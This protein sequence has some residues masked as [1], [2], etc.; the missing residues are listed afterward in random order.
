MSSRSVLALRCV[1]FACA[2]WLS[3]VLVPLPANA[4][5]RSNDRKSKPQ[6]SSHIARP[7]S[8]ESTVISPLPVSSYL[9]N[10]KDKAATIAV[11]AANPNLDAVNRFA[12]FLRATAVVLV[13]IAAGL[14]F[15]KKTGLITA[16]GAFAKSPQLATTVN[17]WRKQQ[18]FVSGH[19][20]INVR[21][22]KALPGSPSSTLHVVEVSGRT[23]LIGATPRSM[24]VVAEWDREPGGAPVGADSKPFSAYL[25]KAGVTDPTLDWAPGVV[26]SL[27]AANERLRKRL[28][29]SSLNQTVVPKDTADDFE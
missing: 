9:D 13:L 29:A 7:A 3:S 1:T 18:P 4:A 16:D 21:S 14:W 24:T 2:I 11:A 8:R 12:G 15:A 26:S 28:T 20:A 17:S 10:T 19:D 27:S 5:T 25:E 6:P 23:F 22:T